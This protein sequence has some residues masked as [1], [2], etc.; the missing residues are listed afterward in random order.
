MMKDKQS[1]SE[2]RG[3]VLILIVQEH[4]C[5]YICTICNLYSETNPHTM[6]NRSGMLASLTVFACS[7]VGCLLV[8]TN[9]QVW[10]RYLLQ[11]AVVL[12]FPNT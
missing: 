1:L 4:L 11:Y 12:N 2:E 3:V 8:G 9:G 7:A 5:A 10:F 6:R